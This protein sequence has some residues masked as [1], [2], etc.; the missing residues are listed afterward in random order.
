MAIRRMIA[1]ERRF[2]REPELGEKVRAQIAEYERKG[3]AHK[4]RLAELTSVEAN[5][6]W[7]LPLGIVT[8]PKKPGKVRLI[9]DAAAKVGGV[10]FNSKLLKG[11][12]LL[13]PLPQVLC[14]FRQFPVAVCGDIMEMFHQ[15]KIR[16]PD[17]QSQRFIFRN[18]P[19]EHPQIYV[20]DVAT[21]GATCSPASA[22]HVKNLNA[23]EFATKFPKAAAAILNNHYVDD[24]LESFKTIQE[25]IEV[26]KEVKLVHSKGGFTLR[27]FLSN[28][29]EVLCGI[30]EDGNEVT[31]TLAL[32]RGEKLESVL[33]MKWLP[34]EDVFVYSLG[35]RGDILQILKNEH[36]PS[37]REVLKVVMSLF[38]PL[39]FISFF[40]I[41]GKILIQDIWTRGTEW[42]EQ[43]A[44]DLFERW[45]QWTSLFPELDAL[46]IP[47]CYFRS[48]FP[49][50]LGKIQLHMFVDASEKAYSCVAYF[51]LE[52]EGT[53]QVA[54]VSAKTKVAPLK[55]VS[56]PRLELKAAV[57]GT[58]LANT[59]KDQHNF[60]I[61]RQFMWSDAGVCL[62]WIRS[63]DHRRYHQFVSVR[64][65]EILTS[66]EPQ[67]W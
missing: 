25:A 9:W 21:F 5:R 44:E 27:H 50:S 37:K 32:E 17:C 23:Q 42:D 36:I 2:E 14:Q 57:L 33:G 11:P 19:A 47:R 48:P 13:T 52:T 7:Y 55:T 54:F 28:E 65:V 41:H 10:S 15:I 12:D 34:K 30:E 6:V 61:A 39:G 40:I 66:T 31:K 63:K 29:A 38:D 35:L 20:M 62:A 8:N 49:K 22:Q 46:R 4:A 16:A 26:V 58:R 3:Y 18:N 43:I 59:I 64:V 67:D 45:R 56:I 60:A 53:I 51:R 1:L 24:Y